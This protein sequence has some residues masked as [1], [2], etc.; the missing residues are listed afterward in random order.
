MRVSRIILWALAGLFAVVLL[1]ALGTTGCRPRFVPPPAGTK[2][3]KC[4]TKIIVDPTKDQGVDHKAV[5]VCDGDTLEWDNPHSATFTVSFPSGDCPFNSCADIT[6]S[7]P[8]PFKTLPAGLTVYKYT[9]TVNGTS[10]DPH[11]VGG[12][13]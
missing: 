6:D 1:L 4:T 3:V 12:G 13:G 7:N 8:R 11:V 10:Y 2:N 9:I 5:Y